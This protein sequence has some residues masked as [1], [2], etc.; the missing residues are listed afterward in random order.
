MRK[1]DTAYINGLAQQ[2]GCR[3]ASLLATAEDDLATLR[4]RIAIVTTFIHDPAWDD[5]AR[6]TLARRL[7]LPEPTPPRPR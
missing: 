3:H 5:T 6:R 4:A 2:L 7:G 1:P